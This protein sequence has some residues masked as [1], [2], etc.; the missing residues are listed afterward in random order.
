MTASERGSIVWNAIVNQ[1]LCLLVG[2]NIIF[3]KYNCL[4][5]IQIYWTV[6]WSIVM[7]LLKRKSPLLYIVGCTENCLNVQIKQI[8]NSLK[9]TNLTIPVSTLLCMTI[10]GNCFLKRLIWTHSNWVLPQTLSDQ[11]Y[12]RR[13]VVNSR[14]AALFLKISF[15][16]IL[17]VC[18][19]FYS[20][21][22]LTFSQQ[23]IAVAIKIFRIAAEFF[24]SQHMLVQV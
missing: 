14:K 17:D 3:A 11:Y 18:C 24:V 1:W 9:F 8:R 22:W 7:M 23:A 10:I 5:L 15:F 2:G 4:C 6:V 21:V 16:I 20:F 19:I 13:R 12:N